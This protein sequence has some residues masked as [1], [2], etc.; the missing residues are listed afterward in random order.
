MPARADSGP[1]VLMLIH[2]RAPFNFAQ[3]LRFILAPPALL[4][5]RTFAP[6][7]DYFVD[8]EYRRVLELGEQLVLYGVREDGLPDRKSVV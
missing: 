2:P 6:L 7:L 1:S 5:G 3:T 4:N 8:G